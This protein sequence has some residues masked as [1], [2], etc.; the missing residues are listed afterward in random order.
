MTHAD[1]ANA[2]MLDLFRLEAEEQARALTAGLLV[3][4][5]NPFAADSLEACM[6]AA[7][8]LKGAA[9]IINLAAGVNIAHTMESCFV[10]AQECRTRLQ[11]PQIDDLLR[12]VD[13][14]RRIAQTPELEL[15][16]W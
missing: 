12:A 8:S 3:L 7:H 1:L 5:R 9:R 11:Q 13:L 10:A 4:E 15:G 6:R 2:S 16:L 14:L